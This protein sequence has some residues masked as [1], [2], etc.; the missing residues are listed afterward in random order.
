MVDLVSARG[1]DL[2]VIGT[3]GRTGLAHAFVGRVAEDLLANQTV[4]VLTLKAP[5]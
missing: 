2:L 4:E 5:R 3:Q 1:A